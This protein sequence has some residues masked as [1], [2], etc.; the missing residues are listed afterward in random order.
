M[1]HG[2][3]PYLQRKL[4]GV[5]GGTGL[6]GLTGST[7]PTGPSGPTGGTGN[8]GPDITGMTLSNGQ[9]ITSFT[10][11]YPS[12]YSETNLK[13]SDGD[14]FIFVDGLNVASGAANVFSGV[15]FDTFTYEQQNYT[16]SRLRI[17]GITT[18]S[19]NG[20]LNMIKINSPVDS[21]YV[22]V[23]YN[24]TGL[25]YLGISSG[26]QGQLI[27][28]RG[29]NTFAGLTGTN[30]DSATQTV[31]L[32]TL[33]YGERVHYVNATKSSVNTSTNNKYYYWFIDWEKANT[34]VLNNYHPREVV[35]EDTVA[36]VVVIRN[37]P[38]ADV[39]K[40][41]TIIVPPG[42]TS[43]VLT[44][45]AATDNTSGFTLESGDYS[46][47]WPMTYP[48]CFSDGTDV[49][50]MVSFDGVWYANYGIYDSGTDIVSWNSSYN[51]CDGSTNI[52]DP[53]YEPV[54]LC[55]VGCSAGDSFV[56]IRS[57]CESYINS[58]EGYFFPGKN[59]SYAGCTGSNANVG[60][61][62]YKNANGEIT[63]HNSPVRAC[64]CLR[65]AKNANAINFWSHWQ[66]ITSCYKNI[67]AIDC[68]A[69]YNGNGACCNGAGGCE[70]NV[71]QTTCAA[72][73]KYWQGKGTVCSYQPTIGTAAY[74]ICKTGTGGCCSTGTC[75]NVSGQSS[76]SG[77]YYGCGHTCGEF[78]CTTQPPPP[79]SCTSC[80]DNN[81]IFR[82]KKYNT[83]GEFTGQYTDVKIGDFF[84]GGIVAG[85]FNPNGATCIGNRQA[86]SGQY[87]GFPYSHYTDAELTDPADLGPVLFNYQNSGTEKTAQTYRTVYDP[88]GYGF[89][90]SDSNSSNCDSWLII[91]SPWNARIDEKSNIF[92]FTFSCTPYTD[93]TITIDTNQTAFTDLPIVTENEIDY[94]QRTINTFTWSHGGTS[95]CLTLDDNLDGLFASTGYGSCSLPGSNISHD[96]CYGTLPITKNG[97]AG[98]TYYGNTTS[99]D[100]CADVAYT[101]T[102]CYDSPLARTSLGQSFLFT[103]NTGWWSRNWGLYNSSRL[104]GSDLAEYYLRSGNGLGGSLFSN[105][106]ATYGATGYA[107]FT[108]NYF[109]TGTTTAKTTIA[110]GCSVYNRYYYSSEQM[111]NSGYPQ[112]SRW[113][114]PSIDELGFIANQCVNINLQQKL[115]GYSGAGTGIPIGSSTIGANGY[116]W[117]ST[118]CFDEGV[119][120]QYIQATGGMPWTNSGLE[121][122]TI[123]PSDSRY[124]QIQCSQFTKAWVMKFPEYNINT[125]N[126]P[127]VSEFKIKK[128]HDFDDRYELRMVRLIRC[129]QRY[130]DNSSPELLRNRTWTI[131]RLTDAA[132]CNGTNQPINGTISNYSSS[133]FNSDIQTLNIFRNTT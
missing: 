116:V 110:E 73:N 28:H 114:V 127:A 37:T 20:S 57:G 117:S 53:T 21:P 15:S 111:K 66:E 62:C 11:G 87:G 79:S 58:G 59:L 124:K 88:M 112:V 18:G 27:V 118:G 60:V 91:V 12:R 47:S 30:Y 85:V 25:P 36:Q 71:S 109:H 120:R 61:C 130:Y 33:N 104:F 101:C 99:F 72:N 50:N 98:S 8:T 24:L 75:T 42:I 108:A 100:G 74:E 69:A 105:L 77:N 14:Y 129:D 123:S 39:A 44:K 31:N 34:F 17:R 35:G 90:L 103:R 41:L 52:T 43:G 23:I 46:I 82:V 76:C 55:C 2:S 49:I 4:Q 68:T 67:N 3:S 51:N 132:I 125:Q 94:Y 97:I 5:L 13:G 84:A 86:F 38:T 107:G 80:L 119:T 9:V 102:T 19:Q 48:P 126:A 10:A 83:S 78:S 128:A 1:I 95:H 81:E 32:Q 16:T 89:T 96:G 54:G 93:N 133:N 26:T 7:G 56:T 6:T 92:D 113:Y 115:Y 65:I 40:A 63:K 64:D 121:G 45:F 131:P 122:E 22:E 70:D 106:K 29:G